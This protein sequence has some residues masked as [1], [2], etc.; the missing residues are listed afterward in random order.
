LALNDA[1]A[2][3]VNLAFPRYIAQTRRAARAAARACRPT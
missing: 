1:I 2:F 3:F